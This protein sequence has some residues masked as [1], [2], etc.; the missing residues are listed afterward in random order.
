MKK[1]LLILLFVFT[2]LS[3]VAQ[4]FAVQGR[5]VDAENV[6]EGLPSA[7]VRLLKN[8]TTAV[9]AVPTAVAGRFDIAGKYTL[10]ISFVGCE[11]MKKRVELTA[12]RP[13]AR[14][15]DLMLARDVLLEELEVTGLAQELTIKA[16]TFV[17]HANAFRVPEGSTIAALIKQLPGLT[18]DSDGNLTFQGKTVSS[19]L[20]NGKPFIGDA[21]TAMSNIVSDAV[22]DIAVYEK[23]DEEKE[24]AGVHDTDKASVVDLKI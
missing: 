8:D 7:T 1:T 24:F 6:T 15:G 12:K 2:A 10:E 16:D 17:Y 11:T 19:I 21:N 20:V 5:V 13:V 18:M 9:A 23:T 14:L 4:N 22:Q 3:A